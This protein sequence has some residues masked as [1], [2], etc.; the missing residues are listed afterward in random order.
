MHVSW[1]WP[2][3]TLVTV[4]VTFTLKP[5]RRP[6]NSISQHAV[7]RRF[8]MP[9]KMVEF[10]CVI[11]VSFMCHPC[12]IHGIDVID[13]APGNW[14]LPQ[15]FWIFPRLSTTFGRCPSQ[16]PISPGPWCPMDP[17]MDPTIGTSSA[18]LELLLLG[19]FPKHVLTIL[20]NDGVRQWEG[21]SMI[22]PYIVENKSHL[23]NHQPDY[24]CHINDPMKQ[25]H[26]H[27]CPLW[28]SR[29]S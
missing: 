7:N 15:L 3:G 25:T 20:K 4:G 8:A 10:S 21:L 9:Q 2:D 17:T 12:V 11:H 14:Q 29:C 18:D 23:W 26:C 22:F 13:L 6:P 24:D 16:N 19:G 1:S 28:D 5:A 27:K